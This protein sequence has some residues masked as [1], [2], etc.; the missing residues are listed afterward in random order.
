MRTRDLERLSD[1]LAQW[2]SD[3]AATGELRDY[4][5]AVRFHIEQELDTRRQ[6]AEFD[7]VAKRIVEVVR[8]GRR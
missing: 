1:L 2:S 3:H 6:A 8:K 4:V 7:A 5:A